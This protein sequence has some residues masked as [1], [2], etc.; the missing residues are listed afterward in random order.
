MSFWVYSISV[1]ISVEENC[2]SSPKVHQEV[3][4]RRTDESIDTFIEA[5]FLVKNPHFEYFIPAGGR[6]MVDT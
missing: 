4:A 6:G 2:I 3:L 5:L 1:D